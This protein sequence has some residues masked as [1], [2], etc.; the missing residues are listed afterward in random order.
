[1]DIS[2][3]FSQRAPALFILPGM[4][5][6]LLLARAIPA[7][8]WAALAGLALAI[9]SWRLAVRGKSG[10]WLVAFTASAVLGFWGYG[11]ARFSTQPDFE[12][13][14]MPAR[15]VVLE[16]KIQRIM[17][18]E[19]SF[20]KSTGVAR[21]IDASETSRLQQNSL[22]Y[23]RLS[24]DDTA[25][26]NMMRGLTFQATG[27]LHPLPDQVA[28]DSFEGYLKETGIH[29]KFLQTSQA[30]VTQAASPFKQ[31]CHQTNIKFQD[32]LRLGEPAER[33]LSQIYIAMLLGQKAQLTPEQ[34]DRFKITGTMHLFAISGLH[35]GVIATVIW[36][37]L[38]LCRLPSKI[39]PFIGLPLLYFY[40]EV[41]GAAPSAVR[42]FLMVA[43]FWASIAVQRQ[44][45]PLS[46]LA[47]SAV[48][49]LLIQPTQLW[50]MGFQLSYLV[51]ISIILFGLPLREKL[52]PLLKPNKFL[53]EADWSAYQR[54]KYRLM[55]KLLLLLVISVSAWLASA[56]L[57]AGFF[58]FIAPYAIPVN[59]LLVNLAALV[60]STGAIA[61]SVASLGLTELTAFLNHSAWL[62][63]S[64][65]DA[66]VR[67][68]VELPGATVQCPN[69][70]KTISYLGVLI[71]TTF[72]LTA[73]NKRHPMIR[74]ALP[75][76]IILATLVIGL[77]F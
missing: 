72:I 56:P 76:I 53:P 5:A 47:A 57:S 22:I 46:A 43:F 8:P 31:L 77:F 45:S 54:T 37:L 21:V 65:M 66:I 69:F 4:L 16:L 35:I 24:R 30:Q 25:E 70:P 1:V 15:E 11:T 17:Q 23:F 27:V 58:G 10:L 67:L 13:L 73:S 14:S 48:L 51:V 61:L 52:W 74:F 29:Y 3:Q 7:S 44:R 38:L 9:L 63:I 42:A 28:A 41:T 32:F 40:V 62:G 2:K 33:E 50:Q 26:L 6:G 19:N 64:L 71:Y 12:R 36:Q 60:I 18:A 34:K 55:D 68:N 59:I 39:T 75:P 49:V 20:G